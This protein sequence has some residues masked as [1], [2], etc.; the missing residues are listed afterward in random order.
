MIY[1]VAHDISV[2]EWVSANITNLGKASTF[3]PKA[4]MV[5]PILTGGLKF[6]RLCHGLRFGDPR[7]STRPLLLIRHA[8]ALY[9][10]VRR[11]RRCSAPG[12]L[13]QWK[14]LK[15]GSLPG[16]EKED[17]SPL[18]P[19]CVP[20]CVEPSANTDPCIFGMS[21]KTEGRRSGGSASQSQVV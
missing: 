20:I 3:W 9:L 21:C 10:S 13:V 1:R 19:Y 7:I 14:S 11:F 17:V 15:N 6:T 8:R 2:F 5:D 12:L 4:E 16:A 18:A